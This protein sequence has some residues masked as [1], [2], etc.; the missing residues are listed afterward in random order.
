M[1]AIV[2]CAGGKVLSRQPSFRKLMEHK[3]NKVHRS[4]ACWVRQCHVWGS[5]TKRLLFLSLEF[6][7]NSFNI[8]WKWP[9]LVSRV[10]C[11]RNRYVHCSAACWRGCRQVRL[12]DGFCLCSWQ[13]F[14]TPSLFS[15]ECSLRHWTTSHILGKAVGGPLSVL[16]SPPARAHCQG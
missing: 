6:V 9:S 14:T 15:L 3:Q 10:F 16:R 2:E 12:F 4:D 11:Q 13:M 7:G 5:V 1:K 8:L